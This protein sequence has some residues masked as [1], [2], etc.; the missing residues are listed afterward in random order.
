MNETKK[1]AVVTREIARAPQAT[2]KI[3]PRFLGAVAALLAERMELEIADDGSIV[4]H[5]TGAALETV[6]GDW[7][8]SPDAKP[9]LAAAGPGN[10]RAPAAPAGKRSA[11]NPAEKG[12]YIRRFGLAAYEQLPA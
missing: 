12:A 7:V 6:V 1:R 11:M 3:D 10:G 8:A 5:D 9:F 4:A 2:G